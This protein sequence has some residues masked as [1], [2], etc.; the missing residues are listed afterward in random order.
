MDRP[1][2]ATPANDAALAMIGKASRRV[3]RVSRTAM[4]RG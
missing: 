3:E 1:A 2:A 4:M